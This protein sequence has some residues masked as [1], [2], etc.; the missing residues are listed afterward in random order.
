MENN[1]FDVSDMFALLTSN[2]QFCIGSS[3]SG[4]IEG[5]LNLVDDRVTRQ[6][7]FQ[8]LVSFFRQFPF[9]MLG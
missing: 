9:F 4:D 3:D 7:I 6:V 8:Y 2:L 1:F 5:L